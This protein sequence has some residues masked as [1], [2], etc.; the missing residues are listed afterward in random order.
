MAD[1]LHNVHFLPD[2]THTTGHIVANPTYGVSWRDS[3]DMLSDI[4]ES[5]DYQSVSAVNPHYSTVD[6]SKKTKYR[7][8]SPQE[9]VEEESGIPIPGRSQNT[10][11]VTDGNS[12]PKGNSFLNSSPTNIQNGGSSL[13]SSFPSCGSPMPLLLQSN[14]PQ[15]VMGSQ[16]SQRSDSSSNSES[17]MEKRPLQAQVTFSDYS[18][19]RHPSISSTN[20]SRVRN[21]SES[22]SVGLLSTQT[23][24]IEEESEEDIRTTAFVGKNDESDP[25]KIEK[26]ISYGRYRVK[27]YGGDRLKIHDFTTTI[28]VVIA[29]FAV[30]S[31]VISLVVIILFIALLVR[32]N[33]SKNTIIGMTTI[34]DQSTLDSNGTTLG[35][36]DC[37]GMFNMI[38]NVLFYCFPCMLEVEYK[39]QYC[40]LQPV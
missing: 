38:T 1:V 17:G 20:S 15:N 19:A 40:E 28:D 11:T 13:S 23:S 26:N 21:V 5:I 34:V 35:Q 32:L 36:C 22:Q 9:N 2:N 7:S 3:T 6:L 12:G 31:L 33:N 14:V 10:N 8:A 18:Y 4:A 27:Q 30:V 29:I 24:R 37:P 39:L 25:Q 16:A